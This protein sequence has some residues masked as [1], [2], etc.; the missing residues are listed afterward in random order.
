MV[1][2]TYIVRRD[3]GDEM[4]EENNPSDISMDDVRSAVERF[5][6]HS[7]LDIEFY[8]HGTYN[9][10]IVNEEYIFRFASAHVPKREAREILLREARV[11]ETLRDYFSIRIPRPEF[12]DVESGTPV[13]GY[14]RLPGISLSRCYDRTTTSQQRDLATQVVAFLKELHSEETMTLLEDDSKFSPEVYREEWASFFKRV[15][16]IVYPHI[17]T[18]SIDW[19]DALF[20]KFLDNTDNF[21]FDPRIVH[22]DFDTSN[23][24]VDP[25][26]F[27]ITGIIDFEETGVYDPAADLLFLGEGSTFLNAI[28]SL[29]PRRSD[30]SLRNRIKFQFGRQPLL[31]I[32]YGLEN[33]IGSMVEY[34]RDAL[35][36]LISEWRI[37]ESMIDSAFSDG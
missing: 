31:Y 13:M 25:E 30:P 28:I 11:L 26:T 7:K 6:P 33:K 27:N 12:I 9:V 5:L 36:P 19:V 37:Y 20:T 1:G 15:Q 14:R 16:D 32:T 3:T 22:G 18:E 29:Y 35:E 8:Y 21:Q 17:G 4:Y 24:L 2:K 10:F 34:G 23:I